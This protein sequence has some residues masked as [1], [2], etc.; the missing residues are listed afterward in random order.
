MAR[1]LLQE[2]RR[3]KMPVT[4]AIALIK[5][6]DNPALGTVTDEGLICIA[7]GQ[8]V[9]CIPTSRVPAYYFWVD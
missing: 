5:N 6:P 8:R 2:G 4:G 3:I 9:V 7:P 1:W